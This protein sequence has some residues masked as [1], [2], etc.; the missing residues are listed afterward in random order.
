MYSFSFCSQLKVLLRHFVV[1]FCY[2]YS[3]LQQNVTKTRTLENEFRAL[4]SSGISIMSG[5]YL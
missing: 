4:S 1:K 5:M 2:I 3:K